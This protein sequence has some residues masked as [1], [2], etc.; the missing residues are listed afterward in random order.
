M[1]ERFEECIRR[2]YFGCIG[3]ARTSEEKKVYASVNRRRIIIEGTHA[4]HQN[5]AT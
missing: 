3:T 4:E 1:L 2:S 5:N